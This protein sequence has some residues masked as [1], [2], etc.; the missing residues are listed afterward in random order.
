MKLI[1][2]VGLNA[3]ETFR[4][5]LDDLEISDVRVEALNSDLTKGLPE[6]AASSGTNGCCTCQPK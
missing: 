5:S 6:M 1:D 4:L 3:K 2:N